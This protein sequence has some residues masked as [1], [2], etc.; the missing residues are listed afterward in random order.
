MRCADGTFVPSDK[1]C[2]NV[3]LSLYLPEG[4][5]VAQP[6]T[7]AETPTPAVEGTGE[8]K[9]ETE[10]EDASAGS[11]YP[12]ISYGSDNT[13]CNHS[14]RLFAS[15]ITSSLTCFSI[16]HIFVSSLLYFSLP[17]FVLGRQPG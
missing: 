4:F 7:A 13:R 10:G 15:L 6:P 12:D 1:Q 3:D 5:I 8:T 14:H 11:A 9:A 17:V 16:L 2:S